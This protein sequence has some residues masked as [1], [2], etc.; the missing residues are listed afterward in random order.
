VTAIDEQPIAI[1]AAALLHSRRTEQQ[2]KVVRRIGD[3]QSDVGGI[4]N[5]DVP[6]EPRIFS[7]MP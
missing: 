4:V 7:G 1:R 3:P 2:Q 6:R 5:G